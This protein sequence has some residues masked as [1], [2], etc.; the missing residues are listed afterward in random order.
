M[1]EKKVKQRTLLQNKSMHLFFTMLAEELNNA[2][3]DMKAVLKPNVEI[4]WSTQT[5]K[6]FLWRPIQR[7]QLGKRSTTE[8]TTKDIDAI[9]ETLNRHIAKFGVHVPFP[10]IEGQ[11]LIASEEKLV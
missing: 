1:D 6:D 4:P 3:L 5:I 11:S 8:L 10:S 9:Y 2:G 7:M